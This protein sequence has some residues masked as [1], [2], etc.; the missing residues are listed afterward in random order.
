MA[1]G[2][3]Y[4]LALAAGIV[5]VAPSASARPAAAPSHLIFASNRDGDTDVYATDPGGRRLAAL[6]V[7]S[8]NEADVVASPDGRHIAFRRDA[9]H[10]SFTYVT[11]GA[12]RHLARVGE[13]FPAGWS[14]DGSR[15]AFFSGGGPSAEA[16]GL[17]VADADGTGVKRLLTN[18]GTLTQFEGWSADGNE[19]AFTMEVVEP[20]TGD[21]ASELRTVDLSGTQR[22]LWSQ[23]GEAW[24]SASWS[25]HGHQLAYR[26]VTGGEWQIAVVDAD[27]GTTSVVARGKELGP[28]VWSPDGTKLLYSRTDGPSGTLDVADLASGAI[29]TLASTAAVPF[30]ATAAWAWSPTGNRVLWSD[31]AGMFVVGA[32]GQGRKRLLKAIAPGWAPHGTWSPDGTQ[33]AFVLDGL[34]TVRPDGTGPKTVAARG[35]ITFVA[36]VGGGIP[37]TARKAASLPPLERASRRLLRL[38]GRIKELVADGGTAGVVSARSRLDCVH[39]VAWSPRAAAVARATQPQPCEPR[40]PSYLYLVGGLD[41]QDTKLTWSSDWSCGNTECDR[42][43][44]EGALRRPGLLEVS[45]RIVSVFYNGPPPRLRCVV[46]P[47]ADPTRRSPDVVRGHAAVYVRSGAVVVRLLRTGTDHVL[48][49]RAIGP[50]FARLT[51]AGLFYA[52]SL[53]GGPYPGR[54]VFVPLGELD[55]LRGD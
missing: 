37:A 20:A 10:D 39:V 18:D 40:L 55:Q 13:G 35:A 24:L 2:A 38:R 4:A 8:R 46:C 11:D 41:I 26:R 5:L 54:V 53:E 47:S 1:F 51:R 14:P 23:L 16:S 48:R 15:L 34:R 42:T 31:S 27:S 25:P 9:R 33:V 44:Y 22:L 30:E 6:T 19:L 49:P 29:S 3:K 12:G 43:V 45:S 21:I 50:V 32:D 52:Y 7:D 17:S 36:W 28:P